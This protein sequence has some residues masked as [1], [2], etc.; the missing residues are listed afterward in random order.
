MKKT[1]LLASAFLLSLT[2]ALMGEE[3]DSSAALPEAYHDFLLASSSVSPDGKVGVI[4][5]KAD[6]E[7][8][9]PAKGTGTPSGDYLV[10]LQPF[11]ILGRLETKWPYFQNESHGGIS[12]SWTKDNS[13]VL[14]TLESKWGPGD[15]FLAEL[16]DDKLTRTSNLLQIA[17]DLLLPSYRKAKA[18]P[19]ND[20]FDFIFEEGDDEPVCK[21]VDATHVRVHGHAT[22]DPKGVAGSHAWAGT[23]EATWDVAQARFSAQKVSGGRTGKR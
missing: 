18:E 20:T 7:E 9:G 12:T 3:E 2:L 15:I 8:E 1:F 11:E 14:V 4:Y 10:R 5:P 19:Y 21:F 23:I 13:A 17:H 22:T 16:R 6:P